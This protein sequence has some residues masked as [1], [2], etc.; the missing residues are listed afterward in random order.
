V[1]GRGLSLYC[2][3]P[4]EAF[5]VELRGRNDCRDAESVIF[6]IVLG[7]RSRNLHAST[8]FGFCAGLLLV[9]KVCL[10]RY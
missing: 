2:I 8:T 3:V 7:L 1:R 6:V 9:V 5:H 4:I 10:H